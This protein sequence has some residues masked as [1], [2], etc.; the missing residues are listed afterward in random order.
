MEVCPIRG[1]AGKRHT[2]V[3]SIRQLLTTH[4]DARRPLR[5][6]R[7]SGNPGGKVQALVLSEIL[8]AAG[9][10]DRLKL[11][12]EAAYLDFMVETSRRSDD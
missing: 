1:N 7:C 2:A 12:D 3:D 11:R 6:R 9:A 5:Q 10:H 8:F 4:S